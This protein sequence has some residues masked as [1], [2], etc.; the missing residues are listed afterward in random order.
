MVEFLPEYVVLSADVQV[1]E[2][3]VRLAEWA[4][5]FT[6]VGLVVASSSTSRRE[7][8]LV[9]AVTDRVEIA[10]AWAH[11]VRPEA[12]LYGFDALLVIAPDAGV[13]EWLEGFRG[14]HGPVSVV[15][16]ALLVL[17]EADLGLAQRLGARALAETRR[18]A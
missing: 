16:A 11:T 5:G 6:R 2:A 14:D 18:A 17:G 7:R 10:A 1:A 15:P 8:E 4:R 13:F 9:A 12:D 3:S